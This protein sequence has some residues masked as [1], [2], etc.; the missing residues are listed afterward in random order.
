MST[1]LIVCIIPSCRSKYGT[2]T[3]SILCSATGVIFLSW[4]SFQEILEFLNFLYAIG[5]LLEFAAFIKLRVKKPD[6]HRPYKVPFQTFGATMLCLPPALLLVLVMCLASL[7]TYFVSGCVII[8]GV[9]LYPLLVHAKDRK[10]AHFDAEQPAEPPFNCPAGHSSASQLH[11]EDAD[12]ASVGLL[13]DL[14]PG[15]EQ[16]PSKLRSEEVLKLE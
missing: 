11:P 7:R 16:E 3:V 4:M 12:E 8:V 5:M 15:T 1:Y 9:L 14:S 10:W 6:L 2:P 13:T